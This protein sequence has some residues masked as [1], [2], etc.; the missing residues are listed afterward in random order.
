MKLLVLGHSGM[1]GNAVFRYFKQ[2]KYTVEVLPS[3]MRW[4]SSEMKDF[5]RNSDAN[6]I[7]NCIGA[8]PQKNPSDSTFFELNTRLPLFLFGLRSKMIL[9]A[10][11]DCEFSGKASQDYFYKED[12]YLDATDIYGISKI[13]PAEV[14]RNTDTDSLKMIRSSI[15]G[16][17]MNTQSSLLNWFLSS[18]DE[19]RMITGYNNH[20]WNGIT[21]LEWAKVA[22]KIIQGIYKGNI[23]QPASEKISK[24][25][26]LKFMAAVFRPN[27]IISETE[28]SK[29]QNK[30]LASNLELRNIKD[31][32]EELKTFYNY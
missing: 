6:C 8:I 5:I 32:L 10:A 12:D 2:G 4:P 11:T 14:L 1:L 27:C 13:I 18:A 25:E 29:Y 15:I 22:E 21:T 7:M 19:G 16:I 23:F 31:M 30:C 3:G 20:Y 17:E 9:H 26:L 28:H 24:Y